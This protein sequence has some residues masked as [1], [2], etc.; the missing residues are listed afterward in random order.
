MHHL[1][2]GESKGNYNII[3]PFFDFVL[4]T[5]TSKVDNTLHFSKNQPKTLQEKWLKEHLVFE[6]R[7]LDNNRIEYRDSGRTQWFPIP[8]IQ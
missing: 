7:V 3:C 1:N 6:I 4:G 8:E 2:K 5:Y